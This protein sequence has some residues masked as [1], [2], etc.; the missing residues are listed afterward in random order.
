M[1][2]RLI[3]LLFSLFMVLKATGQEKQEQDKRIEA[4][5]IAFVTERLNLS[6]TKPPYFGQYTMSF[7]TSKKQFEWL[8]AIK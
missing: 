5:K 4:Y 7:M 1:K 3:Y 8:S 6:S 2:N